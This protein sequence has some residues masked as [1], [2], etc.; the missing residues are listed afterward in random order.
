MSSK[1]L[2][3]A[4][5]SSS[6]PVGYEVEWFPRRPHGID[7]G[8]ALDPPV[9]NPFLY[10]HAAALI[11]STV[12]EL[13][14]LSASAAFLE[15]AP[16]D[17]SVPRIVS[18]EAGPL[19]LTGGAALEALLDTVALEARHDALRDAGDNAA[20]ALVHGMIARN[21]TPQTL[22]IRSF[23]TPPQYVFVHRAGVDFEDAGAD[24]DCASEY[25][26]LAI[27]QKRLSRLRALQ[28]PAPFVLEGISLVNFYTERLFAKAAHTLAGTSPPK[29]DSR[30][31]TIRSAENALRAVH[32]RIA[33]TLMDLTPEPFAPAVRAEAL[34]KYCGIDVEIQPVW[35][36]E[37]DRR[38]HGALQ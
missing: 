25:E 13:D 14:A 11:G 35:A 15:W 17:G 27:A 19:E 2:E 6:H 20:A 33:S 30:R 34:R 32:V 12:E 7:A 3:F 5:T 10:R 4:V 31:E 23:L 22:M 26:A 24:L 18:A 16:G 21:A 36:A 9:L 8:L 37:T 29:T 38:A 1:P 28:A